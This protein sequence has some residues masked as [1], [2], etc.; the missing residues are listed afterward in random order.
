[1][2]WWVI[3]LAFELFLADAVRFIAV[4]FSESNPAVL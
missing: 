3:P 1:M 2:N 4:D